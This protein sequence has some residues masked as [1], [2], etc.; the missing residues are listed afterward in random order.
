M[1]NVRIFLDR[2]N[3]GTKKDT[4]SSRDLFSCTN[5]IIQVHGCIRK[6]NLIIFI[7]SSSKHNFTNVNLTKRLQIPTKNIQSTRLEGEKVQFFKDLKITM[8]KYVL[9]SYF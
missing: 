1:N 4:N 2:W 3:H 5:I 9:H 6:E 7:N 8:D